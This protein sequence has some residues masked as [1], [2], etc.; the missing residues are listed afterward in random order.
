VLKHPGSRKALVLHR[1]RLGIGSGHLEGP[2]LEFDSGLGSEPGPQLR[3]GFTNPVLNPHGPSRSS[4]TRP[5][6]QNWSLCTPRASHGGPGELIGYR[7]M[8]LFPRGRHSHT[9]TPCVIGVRVALPQV[10]GADGDRETCLIRHGPITL[11]DALWGLSCLRLMVLIQLLG[12]SGSAPRIE[13]DCIPGWVLLRS[14][15]GSV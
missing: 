9:S 12:V 6:G 4:E 15:E 3:Y 8:R 7:S 13:S 5:V 14:H 10:L 1:E 2:V 11:A